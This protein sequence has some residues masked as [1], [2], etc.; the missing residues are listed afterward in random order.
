VPETAVAG[1]VLEAVHVREHLPTQRALDDVV[2]VEMRG[3]LRDLLVR[4][5]L[6]AGLRPEGEVLDD[7]LRRRRADPVDVGQRDVEAL[8][9]GNVDT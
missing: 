5:V 9:V 7:L 4:E 8:V 2:V 6:R 3:D 1:D